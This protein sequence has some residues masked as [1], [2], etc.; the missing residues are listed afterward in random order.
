MNCNLQKVEFRFQFE[1]RPWSQ[2]G[3]A[4]GAQVAVFDIHYSLKALSGF[5]N[6]GRWN[7]VNSRTLAESTRE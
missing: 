5:V 7:S 2:P 4:A 3:A 1:L 6:L